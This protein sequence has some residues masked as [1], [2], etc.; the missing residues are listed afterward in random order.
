MQSL[1]TKFISNKKAAVQTAAFLLQTFHANAINY[2]IVTHLLISDITPPTITSHLAP[3]SLMDSRDTTSFQSQKHANQLP[4]NLC[5]WHSFFYQQIASAAANAC[6]RSA[7]K[8]RGSSKPTDNRNKEVEIPA[9]R[10]SSSVI[11]RW[12]IDAG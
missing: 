7:I 11:A 10:C 5:H 8:S 1:S 12:V 2:S 4:P 9:A 6:I 3:E